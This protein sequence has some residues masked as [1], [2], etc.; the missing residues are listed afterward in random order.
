MDKILKILKLSIFFLLFFAKGFSQ[1]KSFAISPKGDTINIIDK[2]GMKQGKWI[3]TVG[4]LRG[5]PGYEE[6]GVF[7][8]NI[9]EGTWRRYNLN[10]DLL[11]R[12]NFKAGGKEGIQQY[13]TMLGDL[14][15]EESWHAYN[16]DA[17][18]DTIPIYG[19]GSSEILSYKI[20]KAEP[21]SVKD[22][23]WKFYDPSTGMIIKTE[24]YDRGFLHKDA[25]DQAFANDTIPKKKVKPKEV[26]EYEKKNSGKK[27]V[28]VREG[29]TNY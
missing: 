22:G 4:E 15:R 10:G 18:Y 12:E 7:K 28:K 2:K 13:Y 14:L 6:E 8:N 5:E 20:I 26:L 1:Y 17:P 9:Q 11:A 16:P 29:Q 25:N 3:V 21:Y 24:K 27:K 19:T 23:E